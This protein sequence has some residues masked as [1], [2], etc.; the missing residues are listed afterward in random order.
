M[1]SII[2][3]I[4]LALLIGCGQSEKAEQAKPSAQTEQTTEKAPAVEEPAAPAQTQMPEQTAAATSTPPA[5]T[6]VASIPDAAKGATTYAT[7]CSTCHGATGAGDG[8]AAAALNPKP[9]HH[10]DPE[11]MATLTDEILFNAVKGGGPAVGKS[12]LMPAWSAT[13]SDDQIHDVVAFMRTL[14]QPK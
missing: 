8:P 7:L 11:F 4:L 1:R 9:A 12:P 5:A 10:N 6:Q 3:L 13:L 14:S 2:S